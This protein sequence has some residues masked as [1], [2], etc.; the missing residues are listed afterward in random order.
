MPNAKWRKWRKKIKPYPRNHKKGMKIAAVLGATGY[1]GSHVVLKLLSEGFFVRCGTRNVANASWLMNSLQDSHNSNLS[2]HQTDF[3]DDGPCNLSQLDTLFEGC[4]SVFLCTG[5]ETQK[6]ETITFMVNSA[7]K[8]IQS[9]KKNAVKTVVL[10]SSGGSTNPTLALPDGT[11]KN[12]LLHWSDPDIQQKN[13]KFSPAAKTLMELKAL[14]EVGRDKSNKIIDQEKSSTNPRL[15][16]MNPNLIL[17]PQLQPGAVSGNS[18]PWIVKILK[19]EAMNKQIPND[20]MSIIDVRDLASL[21]VAAAMNKNAS[22]RYFGVNKSWPWEEILNEL[23]EVYPNYKSKIPPRFEGESATPTQFDNTR[24]DSL[25]IT[26]RP[27]K[28]TLKDLVDFLVEKD[29]L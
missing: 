24:R 21:H 27:L 10:T 26:L 9:A 6:P 4:D 19:G 16:I 5:F 7:L 11:P 8:T 15:V 2:I 17:G 14:E 12:E 29:M 22:G 25:G 1:V 13:L 20:S 28:E 3:S 18:L 23:G